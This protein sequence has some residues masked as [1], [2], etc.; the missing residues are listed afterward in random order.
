M[1]EKVF[2]LFVFSFVISS[3]QAQLEFEGGLKIGGITSQVA[4]D[5]YAGYNKIGITGGGFIEV[6]FSDKNSFQ[7]EILYSNKGSRNK[8]DTK[9]GD[10][11]YYRLKLNYIE[12]PVSY[13]F[14]RDKLALEGGLYYGILLNSSQD[15]GSGEREVVPPYLN[16]DFGGQI[17]LGYDLLEDQLSFV[18][19]GSSSILPTRKAPVNANPGLAYISGGF[20]AAISFSLEYTF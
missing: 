18:I 14:H 3:T 9:N 7:M 8:P 12:I 11:S 1:I 19:V 15:N 13:I 10:F 17:G 20:N 4:G 2:A 6:L 16:Y 5:T